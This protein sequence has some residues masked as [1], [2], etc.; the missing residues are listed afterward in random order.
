M[1]YLTVEEL[2]ARF[3]EREIELLLDRDANGLPD[4][5]TADAAIADAS[6]EVD[7]ILG[8]RYPI[9]LPATAW[10]KTQVA[11]LARFRLY[12]QQAPEAVTQ[13]R[14]GA[15]RALRDVASGRGILLDSS[16][17]PVAERTTSNEAGGATVKAPARY[18][19]DR[20]LQGYL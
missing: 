15:L 2:K 3:G 8:G 18:L 20:T 6:G 11:D 9:P 10:I 19:D 13:R 1:A 16:G 5:G 7:T 12:D 17:Q 4:A 14:E